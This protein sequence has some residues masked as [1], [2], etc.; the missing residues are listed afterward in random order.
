MKSN[1]D[2][3]VECLR[4]FYDPT[5]NGCLLL[6]SCP[7]CLPCHY[8]SFQASSFTCQPALP[9]TIVIM[10]GVYTAKPDLGL[11]VNRSFSAFVLLPALKYL[12][13]GIPPRPSH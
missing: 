4:Y 1:K 9:W 3:A 5:V 2:F 10:L 7:L 12:I 11:D 6:K 13:S 8:V